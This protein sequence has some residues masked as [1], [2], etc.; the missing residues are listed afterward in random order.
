M[1][2][3]GA[4]KCYLSDPAVLDSSDKVVLDD[5]QAKSLKQTMIAYCS[6]TGASYASLGLDGIY[7]KGR[8]GVRKI[9]SEMPYEARETKLMIGRAGR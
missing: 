1:C 6:D 2:L 7:H 9:T 3:N 8:G 5:K 4:G